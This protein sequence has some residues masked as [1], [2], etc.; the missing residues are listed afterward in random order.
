[1]NKFTWDDPDDLEES[2]EEDPDLGDA[3]LDALEKQLNEAK[4][5]L[6]FRLRVVPNGV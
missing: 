4:E 2:Q 1:M 3:D 6:S 5:R